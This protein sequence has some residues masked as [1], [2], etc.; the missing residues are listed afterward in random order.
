MFCLARFALISAGAMS[1][2]GP[3]LKQPG[4]LSQTVKHTRSYPICSAQNGSLAHFRGTPI[5]TR[6][7]SGRV[8]SKL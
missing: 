3:V 5:P 7:I 2:A 1:S 4:N 8:R 6:F